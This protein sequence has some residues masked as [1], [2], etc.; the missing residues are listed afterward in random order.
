MVKQGDI[1]KLNFNPQSGHEQ[2][3]FRPAVVISNDFFN[4]KVNM[5]IVCPITYTNRSFPLHIALDDRTKTTGFVLCEHI[6]S[7][8]LEA[9]SYHYVERIPQDLLEEILSTVFSEIEKPE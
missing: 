2:A 7:I 6:K 3:G 8:D 5:T 9:R 1:I 4:E